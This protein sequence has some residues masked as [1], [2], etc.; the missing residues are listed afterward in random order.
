MIKKLKNLFGF[1]IVETMVAISLAMVA[2]VSISSFILF[3]IYA[4]NR[5]KQVSLA[6]HLAIEAMEAVRSFRNQRDWSS[7]GIGSLSTGDD[8]YPWIMTDTASSSWQLSPGQQN[9][10]NFVRWISFEPVSRATSTDDIQDVY[11]PADD[12]PYTRKV[13]V[14]VTRDNAT[15]TIVSYITRWI[16]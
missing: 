8:Y 7:N 6:D 5:N 10:D 12:D 16:E 11:D 2:L 13:T 4:A 3:S 1:S 9:I 14:Y 15:T